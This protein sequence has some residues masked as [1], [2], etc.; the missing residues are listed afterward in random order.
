MTYPHVV[1][2][3]PVYPSIDDY[4][5]QCQACEGLGEAHFK[6]RDL[7]KATQYYKQALAVLAQCKVRYGI[8][9]YHIHCS[10]SQ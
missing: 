3:L 9:E 10:Q 7:E 2:L 4:K 5:G 1:L 6:L 8:P